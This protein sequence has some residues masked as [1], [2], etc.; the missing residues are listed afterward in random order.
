MK[1]SL[2][3]KVFLKKNYPYII[4]EI[5]NNHNGSIALAKKLIIEAKK[6]EPAA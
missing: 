5:G 4:A 1:N 3:E 2:I 6:S